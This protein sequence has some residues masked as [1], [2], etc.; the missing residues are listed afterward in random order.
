MNKNLEQLPFPTQA[1]PKGV[2]DFEGRGTLMSPDDGMDF[3][4]NFMQRSG[5]GAIPITTIDSLPIRNANLCLKIDVEGGELAALKGAE[6]TIRSANSI[7]VGLEA[8]PSVVKRTGID[9]VECLRLLES[10]RQFSFFVSETKQALRT[11]R[12]VFA[13]IPDTKVY[14]VI[15]VSA[16]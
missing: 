4:G 3:A 5:N 10:W 6:Q 14:N 7:V 1:I 13:Q 8:H 11:T 2:A 16:T 12:P 9:P 15:G